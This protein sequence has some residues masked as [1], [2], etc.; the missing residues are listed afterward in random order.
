MSA[1][2]HSVKGHKILDTLIAY[3]DTMKASNKDINIIRVTEDQ[4]RELMKLDGTNSVRVDLYYREY[5]VEII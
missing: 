4:F 3:I 5:K 1:K 2:A